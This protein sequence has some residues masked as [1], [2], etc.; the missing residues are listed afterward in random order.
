MHQVV[1]THSK[2]ESSRSIPMLD[3]HDRSQTE[4]WA[5]ATMAAPQLAWSAEAAAAADYA[6]P[7]GRRSTLG[8]PVAFMAAGA[9]AAAAIAAACAIV[10]GGPATSTPVA[11]PNVSAAI[12]TPA[13]APAPAPA[14]LPAPAPQPQV[15]HTASSNQTASNHAAPSHASNPQPTALPQA[16]PTEVQQPS[17]PWPQQWHDSTWRH[18]NWNFFRPDFDDSH[19]GGQFPGFFHHSGGDAN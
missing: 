5:Q 11:A 19:H 1:E 10:F 3:Y 15:R 8:R 4:T 13:P 16:Q 12:A 7:A 17:T 2:T 9:G 6:V 14:P 18:S